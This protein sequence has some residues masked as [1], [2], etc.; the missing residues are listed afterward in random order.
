MLG[1]AFHLR[2]LQSMYKGS[3][4]SSLST[5]I[6]KNIFGS[7]LEAVGISKEPNYQR[8]GCASTDSR[9]PNVLRAN[10]TLLIS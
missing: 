1:L 10:S 3:K 6:I 5:P 4:N 8:W 7:I 2:N 9:L